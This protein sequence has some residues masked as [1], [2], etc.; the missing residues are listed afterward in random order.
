LY[1]TLKAHDALKQEMFEITEQNILR[2]KDSVNASKALE[3]LMED[4]NKILDGFSLNT[5]IQDY[6]NERLKRY[7]LNVCNH[8]GIGVDRNCTFLSEMADRLS[9]MS[10]KRPTKSDIATFAKKAG[11]N[12]YSEEYRNVVSTLE[13]QR[14][15]MFDEIMRPIESLVSKAG[16][17]L[18]K[19]VTGFISAD[20]SKTS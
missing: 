16:C 20:P 13:S 12:V 11:V 6:A 19:N 5:T 1:E 7:I 4:F 2:M 8:N 9:Y 15:E 17:L 14:E 18:L 10:R 3:M